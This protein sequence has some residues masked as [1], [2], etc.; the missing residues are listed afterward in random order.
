MTDSKPD[1]YICGSPGLVESVIEAVKP[2][3]ISEDEL[4]YE[5]YLASTQSVKAGN[6]P[7]ECRMEAETG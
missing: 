7:R 1:I 5:R 6:G 3:G 2:L 4:I